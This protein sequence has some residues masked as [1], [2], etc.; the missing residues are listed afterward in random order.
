MDFIKT[1]FSKITDV[2][3]GSWKA[4]FILLAVCYYFIFR[5]FIIPTN[6]MYPTL[7]P[8]TYVGTLFNYGV[9]VPFI[10]YTDKPL[11]DANR[12]IP[13]PKPKRGDIVFFRLPLEPQTIYVKRVFGIPGDKIKMDFNGLSLQEGGEG[14]FKRDPQLGV[15]KGVHYDDATQ[16][17]TLQSIYEFKNKDSNSTQTCAMSYD[18]EVK[19]NEYFMVGDN[20]DGSFDSR[21]WGSVPLKLILG[22]ELF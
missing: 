10:P 1:W 3:F 20:R 14:E 22:K 4:V 17:K 12:L 15:Y 18:Y 6:S 2:L 16:C 5:V 9:A 21:F 7:K 11:F 13:G 19:E 8:G